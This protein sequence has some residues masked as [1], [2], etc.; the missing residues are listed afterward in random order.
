MQEKELEIGEW[1]APMTESYAP[2]PAPTKK[3]AHAAHTTHATATHA[4]TTSAAIPGAPSAAAG[5][6][7]GAAASA[8]PPGTEPAQRSAKVVLTDGCVVSYGVLE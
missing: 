8:S 5:A 6:A 7:T 1:P 2:A 3:A 4:T